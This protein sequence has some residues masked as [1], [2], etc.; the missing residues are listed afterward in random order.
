MRL[1]D[2]YYRAF[3]EYRKKTKDDQEAVK[4]RNVIKKS[5]FKN[6]EL[7]TVKYHCEIKEDWIKNIEHGLIFIEKAIGE[8]RQFIRTEGDIVQIEKVRKVSKESVKHLS[9]NSNLITKIPKEG[10]KLIPEK[11]YI[12]EKLND[13]GVYENRFIYFILTYL[14][15]FIHSRLE[16]IEKKVT[17]YQSNMKLNKI[18]DLKNRQINFKLNLED[19]YQKDPFLGE[20]CK[21]IPHLERLDTILYSVRSLLK[22]PLMLEVAKEPMI[23]PPI[24][25][26]NVLKMNPNFRAALELYDYIAAYNKDGYSFEEIKETYSPFDDDMGDE[27]AEV[28]ELSTFLSYQY[29]NEITEHL[30]EV[31]LEEEERLNKESEAL[32]KKE[33]SRLKKRVQE[34][35]IDYEN[36]ILLMEKRNNNLEKENAKLILAKKENDRLKAQLND[37]E[38]K[39]KDMLSEIESLNHTI[40]EKDAENQYLNSKYFRDMTLLESD[41]RVKIE[42][43]KN[44]HTLEVN[45]LNSEHQN[46]ISNILAQTNKEKQDITDH[47]ESLNKYLEKEIIIINDTV[48]KLKAQK[49]EL[50]KTNEQKVIELNNKI[51]EIVD[52]KN[53]IKGNFYAMK[54]RQGLITNEDSFTSREQFK[55]LTKIKKAFNKFF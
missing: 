44:K 37:L 29:G 55:E 51:D 41:H 4:V 23:R 35:N 39:N 43:L 12:V 26:T 18:I 25:K 36:Y 30:K 19:D 33:L 47:Y 3:N 53:Y 27:F 28:I 7:T 17:T 22:M 46:E 16:K 11:L 32:M 2:L 21:N 24:V 52:E 49:S 42:N 31:F 14:E 5:N 40:E 50:I 10:E 34:M 48:T 13:Y 9:R 45:E 15:E 6:D 20:V 54:Q 1:I 38:E 8:E